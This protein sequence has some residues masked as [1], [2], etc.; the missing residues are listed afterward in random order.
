[1]DE[2][3]E[4][5]VSHDDFN[6]ENDIAIFLGP[7]TEMYR[8]IG[9][10][11]LKALM[12]KGESFILLDVRDEEEYAGGHI[13]D[14]VNMPVSVIEREALKFGLDELIIVYGT[15]SMG[16]ESSVAADKFN[17]LF[18]NNVVRYSGG[19]EEWTGAGYCIKGSAYGLM[20]AA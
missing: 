12:D 9:K 11:E 18:F 3:L 16:V 14:A 8:T 2:F 7:I 5:P 20:K 4:T 13:C 10:N 6:R 15:D 17:T 1:M 19:I